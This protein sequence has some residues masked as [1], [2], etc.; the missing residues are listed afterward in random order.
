MTNKDSLNSDHSHSSGTRRTIGIEFVYWHLPERCISFP[1]KFTFAIIQ[2]STRF[3]LIISNRFLLS[4]YVQSIGAQLALG[5]RTVPGLRQRTE[6]TVKIR[7]PS[8]GAAMTIN[9]MLLSMNLEVLSTYPIFCDGWTDIRSVLKPKDLRDRYS[10]P[11]SGSL[12]TSIRRTGTPIWTDPQF[13][14]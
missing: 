2:I 6:L 10:P 3:G 1:V 11:T 4:G 13:Q 14:R 7:A 9:Q 8:F 5:N 12:L